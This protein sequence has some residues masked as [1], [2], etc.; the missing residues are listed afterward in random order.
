[1]PNMESGRKSKS[2]SSV[3]P[4][5]KADGISPAR[6]LLYAGLANIL[7]ISLLTFSFMPYNVWPLA[8]IALVPWALAMTTW[9]DAWAELSRKC[10]DKFPDRLARGR[11]VRAC[12]AL[13]RLVAS[14]GFL[15]CGISL[16][17]L[18]WITGVGYLALVPYLTIYWFVAGWSISPALRRG[19]PAWIVLPVVWVAL[20]FARAYIIS[21][22]EWFFLAH[23]QWSQV[24]L[25]QIAD[26]TGQYGVSFFVAMVNGLIVDAILFWKGRIA[27]SN[28]AR[29]PKSNHANGESAIRI[30]HS[31]IMA[32]K[33][34][35]R[36]VVFGGAA[37]VAAGIF[38]AVYGSWRMGEQT[39]K[40]GPSAGVVQQAYPISLGHQGPSAGKILDDH[41]AASEQ[42]GWGQVDLLLW[43]ESMLPS[44]L[45]PEVLDF[46]IAAA[47]PEQ[48]RDLFCGLAGPVGRNRDKF[49]DELI[50]D[51][52][53]DFVESRREFAAKVGKL[54]LKMDCPI[55]AGG[56]AL[57][58]NPDPLDDNDRWVLAN[59]ALWFDRS[60]RPV[61]EYSKMHLVPFSEYVPFKSDWPALYKLL[62]EFVPDVMPQMEPGKSPTVY[63]LRRDDKSWRIGVAICYEGAFDRV[64]RQIVAQNGKKSVDV[65]A[66]ISNDGWFVWPI[67]N[68][69]ASSEQ[70]QHLAQY[71][72]RAV[73]NRVP[74]VR[75]VNTGIS[76][77]FD[78]CGR[79]QCVL[80]QDGRREMAVGNMLLKDGAPNGNYIL[81]R[82]LLVD[83][84]TS[85]YSL[86]GDVFAMAVT[87]AAVAIWGCLLWNR[88]RPS[89]RAGSPTS[90]PPAGRTK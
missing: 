44:A 6:K 3:P 15:F 7:T 16:Y 20:E 40:P 51:R 82:Q 53:S 81:G 71:A 59:S 56:A 72:F 49:S 17:W 87:L 21:G 2:R 90:G 41:I 24:W 28:S 76:A 45:N 54:S 19:W 74:V 79:L 55:L 78:S 9:S 27:S 11:L 5:A 26:T 23:S 8:Y 35:H 62:R 12:L 52:L 63:T 34:S 46:D 50:L 13:L 29:G 1:M 48:R 66:N 86:R 18:L 39:T 37:T 80:T 57:H 42:F 60:E 25:I 32:A 83:E 69:G 77:S 10:R 68:W 58:R 4:A 84:R 36:P 64:C 67:D 61:A 33:I 70:S 38:L 89:A 73:E 43:A 22:F 31:A 75:A 47:T 88:F 85:V 30:P 65:L 14:A